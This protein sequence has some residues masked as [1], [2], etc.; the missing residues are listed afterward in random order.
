MLSFNKHESII[1]LH[2]LNKNRF[3]NHFT[4]VLSFLRDTKK[5]NQRQA[6]VFEDLYETDTWVILAAQELLILN[7]DL[8][9]FVDTLYRLE[10]FYFFGDDPMGFT[11]GDNDLEWD[12]EENEDLQ[13]DILE[14]LKRFLSD[15]CIEIL[16]E[17]IS[18]GGWYLLEA[19]QEEVKRTRCDIDRFLSR[20]ENYSKQKTVGI[21]LFF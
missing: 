5:I 13:L 11:E 12:P 15:E 17:N 8:P 16:E 6:S 1:N 21:Q 14:K 10:T 19:Y 4:W 7:D 2:S 9:D 20:I 3:F 18:G